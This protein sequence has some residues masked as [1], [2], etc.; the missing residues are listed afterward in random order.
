MKIMKRFV[1]GET[2]T[3]SG[4][5]FFITRRTEKSVWISV[6]TSGGYSKAE[7]RKIDVDRLGSEI[8]KFDDF[9]FLN[10]NSIK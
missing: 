7:R 10:A 3:S 6:V 8:A 1:V 5:D 4:R 9:R 2:Y